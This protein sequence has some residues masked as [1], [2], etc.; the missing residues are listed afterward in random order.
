MEG[1]LTDEEYLR[2]AQSVWQANK[3]NAEKIT[4]GLFAKH[5]LP[6]SAPVLIPNLAALLADLQFQSF[7]HGA[8]SVLYAAAAKT[9]TVQ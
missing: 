8:M 5:R 1:N 3:A 4:E 2:I 7:L 6:P 9:E